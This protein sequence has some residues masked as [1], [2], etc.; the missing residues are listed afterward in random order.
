MKVFM[1]FSGFPRI[2]A[3]TQR[4]VARQVSP[5]LEGSDLFLVPTALPEFLGFVVGLPSDTCHL[6]SVLECSSSAADIAVVQGH[7]FGHEGG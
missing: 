3:L 4:L 2:N 5:G 1:F 7:R 6:G